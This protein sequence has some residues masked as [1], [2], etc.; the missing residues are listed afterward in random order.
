MKIRFLKFKYLI[1]SY[2]NDVFYCVNTIKNTRKTAFILIFY[3]RGKYT[4]IFLEKPSYF[5]SLIF[6]KKNL[7]I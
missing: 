2:L 7:Q 5:C 6:L 3:C 4:N 1:F